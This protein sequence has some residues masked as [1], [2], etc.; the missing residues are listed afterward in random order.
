MGEQDKEEK[1][2][3]WN[4]CPARLKLSS[5]FQHG[6]VRIGSFELDLS[7]WIF[8]IR[9]LRCGPRTDDADTDADT[10]NNA[11]VTDLIAAELKIVGE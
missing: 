4:M 5:P 10:K 7:N 8:R 2:T 1:S 6:M 11:S 3:S 9:S